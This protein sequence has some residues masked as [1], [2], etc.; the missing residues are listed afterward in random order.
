MDTSSFKVM[1]PYI[2]LILGSAAIGALVSSL[3]TFFGAYLERQSRRKDL[4]MSKAIELA[5]LHVKFLQQTAT[6]TGQK[7]TI[8][9]YIAFVRWYHRQLTLLHSTDKISADLEKKLSNFIN[10]DLK[11]S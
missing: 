4:L 6:A 9:P 1:T 10:S 3:I 8:Y 7:V 5:E 11:D 2:P